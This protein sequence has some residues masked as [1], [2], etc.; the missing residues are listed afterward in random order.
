MPDG[1]TLP[2][3]YNGPRYD[4]PAF[5]EA[6]FNQTLKVIKY[7]YNNSLEN[8]CVTDK[9]RGTD[10]VIDEQNPD[11][12]YKQNPDDAF[13]DRNIKNKYSSWVLSDGTIIM[14]YGNFK[15]SSPIY[16]ID[17]NGHKG[18]NKWGYDLF[19]FMLRGTETK[20]ITLL[21]PKTYATEK[22]GFTGEQMQLEMHK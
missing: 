2:S 5:E 8:G 11:A 20:G 17:I 7:C 21:Q 19:S 18:P 13:S 14:K 12:P 22:G 3:D 6:L 9:Y 16:T 10:K 1:S 4:C 15:A